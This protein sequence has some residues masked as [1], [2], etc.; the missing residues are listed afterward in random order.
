M[1][2][3]NNNETN[4]E[5]IEI[6]YEIDETQS[7]KK[8]IKLDKKDISKSFWLWQF[9]SHANY[10][11][12]RMQGTAFAM[13]MSTILEKL[14]KKKEDLRD[15]L[16]RHLT[17][18][19]TEP[20]FGAV[21][22]GIVISMEEEKA[23]GAPIDD[24]SINSVKTGLMGPLAGIGDTMVQGIIIPLIVALGISF[25]TTG[26]LFGPVL[27][28]FGL[29]AILISIARFS[30]MRGYK[31]G[32]SAIT[33]ILAQG[34]M[35][36]IIGA[37]GILGCTVMGALIAQYVNLQTTVSFQIGADAFDLQ[38][39]LFDKLLPSLLP[40]ALTLGVYAILKKGKLNSIHVL[41]AI[42]VIGFAGALLGIF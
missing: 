21:I 5:I 25:G 42:V 39:Q 40:I 13:C 15:G 41:L 29:P 6:D 27:V 20:N 16:K 37:A 36:K 3:T 24:E 12:E 8:I 26:N 33:S 1:S 23:N 35:Q 19:N 18:F 2:S 17:F 4:I 7:N 14:Y 31:M 34:K 11:Y 28:L 30:W 38:T 22:H 32:N 9:F 10:N